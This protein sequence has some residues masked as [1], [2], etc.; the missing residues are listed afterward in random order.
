MSHDGYLMK[1]VQPVVVVIDDDPSV[2]EALQGL[3]ETAGLEVEL[4][5]SPGE[6]LQR[7]QTDAPGCIILDVRLRGSSGLDFQ[8]ELTRAG[9]RTPVIFL[10]GHADIAM[11]V[12]A[13]KAG[14][15]E[16]LTKPYRDQTLIEAVLL[17]IE[18]D[19]ARRESDAMLARVRQRFESLTPRERQVMALAAAG[20]SNKQTAGTIGIGDVTARVHRRQVMRKMQARSIAELVRIVEMLASCG[21]KV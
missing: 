9:D 14:A 10:T 13:M 2:R 20:Q 7:N 17:A 19:R 16:F 5:A 18:N 3:F 11:T 8:R 15:V 4:Y 12:Q 1:D 21:I 6:Y